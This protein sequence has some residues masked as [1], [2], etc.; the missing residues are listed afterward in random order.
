MDRFDK[1]ISFLE[2]V[3]RDPI[4]KEL[5]RQYSIDSFDEKFRVITFPISDLIKRNYEA[6]YFLSNYPYVLSLYGVRDEQMDN[7]STEE[8]PYL[9][10]L[11]CLTWHFRRDYFCQGTLTY[12]SIAEG[13]LLRLFCHLRE[14]YKKNPTVST[15]EELHRT[16]CSS[17]PCQPGIYRVLAPEKLPISFI[18]GSDNLRAKGYP[19]A[20]L[21]QKYG[22]CT[23]KTVLYIGKANGRGGLRQRVMIAMAIA[24]APKLLI[25][26][27]PTTALDVT[28]QAQILEL[29][30]QLSQDMGMSILLITHNFGV[31]AE[32]CQRTSV[33]YAGKVVETGETR[34]LLRSARHPYSRALIRSIPGGGAR[35]SRL[36]TIPGSPPALFEP[37]A[38]CMFAP[39]CPYA[40][41]TCRTGYPA[42]ADCGDGHLAACF[43]PLTEEVSAHV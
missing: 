1:D 41:E 42:M 3:D 16:K 34:E 28:I 23:D 14:L 29:L 22:Q 35:G 33:M 30:Q 32:T 26:D 21:E 2:S 40:D 17:L 38:S 39:R 15:L 5:C 4:L 19:A 6:G 24:C 31:V 8:L 18:E 37:P 25:A 20:I 11:A 10:T 9:A 43:K 7:L 12:R 27:E 36:E 13:T